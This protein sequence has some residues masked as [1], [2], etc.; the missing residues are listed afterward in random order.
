[1]NHELVTVLK[2]ETILDHK[3]CVILY[4]IICQRIFSLLFF[5]F[6]SFFYK[7]ILPITLVNSI[8]HLLTLTSRVLAS[9]RVAIA[10]NWKE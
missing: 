1:M 7:Q 6:P 9:R 4:N 2:L 8:S 10:Y 5:L 3:I